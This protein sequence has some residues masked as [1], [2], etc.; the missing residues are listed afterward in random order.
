MLQRNVD[1]TY[2]DPALGNVDQIDGKRHMEFRVEGHDIIMEQLAWVWNESKA[3]TS[4]SQRLTTGRLYNP[5]TLFDCAVG[6]GEF[7]ERLEGDQR[8]R[9]FGIDRDIS[10]TVQAKAA[11]PSASIRCAD[12]LDL[13]ALHN[14]Y[15]V[16]V[17]TA[18]IEHVTDPDK[19][20]AGIHIATNRWALIMTPNALRPAKVWDAIRGRIR[21]E[22]SGHLQAWDYHLFHQQ[23]QYHGF[24]VHRIDV[25]FVD[26]PWL[27][28]WPWLVKKL[29]YGVLRRWFPMLGSEMFALCEKQ[30]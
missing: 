28:W 17:A 24:K 21:W 9:C 15:D 7:L 12:A 6:L 3:Y 4:K 18:L 14:A 16:V 19:L 11:A 23:L 25:R 26:F 27:H 20:L 13:T 22:R 29:S 30:K 2:H 10:C 8:F 5:M 1:T